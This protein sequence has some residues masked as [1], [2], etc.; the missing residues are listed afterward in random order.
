MFRFGFSAHYCG[1]NRIRTLRFRQ[2]K[3]DAMIFHFY[4]PTI[5]SEHED[6]PT[7]RGARV[8]KRALS[9]CFAYIIIIGLAR[10]L[11][12]TI[13]KPRI[14]CRQIWLPTKSITNEWFNSQDQSLSPSN[15]EFLIF[16]LPNFPTTG[17]IFCIVSPPLFEH[18]LND[19]CSMKMWRLFYSQL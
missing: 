12:I 6:R 3:V 13:I 5:T 10:T 9:T 16:L 18:D 7:A 17:R 14:A 4:F 15:K 19:G 2:K 8:T 1:E 11:H